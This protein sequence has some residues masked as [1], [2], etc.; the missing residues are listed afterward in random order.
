MV[1]VL[2][3][4]RIDKAFSVYILNMNELINHFDKMFMYKSRGKNDRL[5]CFDHR[6]ASYIFLFDDCAINSR[7]ILF[8]IL[9]MV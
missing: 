7:Q 4:N 6:Q 1:L 9:F 2:I 8:D 3:I 5:S